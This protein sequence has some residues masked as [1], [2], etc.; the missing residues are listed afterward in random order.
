MQSMPCGCGN[1]CRGHPHISSI[2]I[3]AV[4]SLTCKK[5]ETD[6]HSST[7]SALSH[8]LGVTIT[9]QNLGFRCSL[10]SMGSLMIILIDELLLIGSRSTL[11]L[12]LQHIE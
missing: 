3:V 6:K 1:G 5:G 7:A 10:H 8:R 2:V 12:V 11:L 4:A 9:A